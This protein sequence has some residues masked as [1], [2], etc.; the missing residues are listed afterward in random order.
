[1][2]TWRDQ[3]GTSAVGFM[4]SLN[5]PRALWILFFISHY[6]E[7]YHLT[8]AIFSFTG[9]FTMCLASRFDSSHVIHCRA[10]KSITNRTMFQ[11][12]IWSNSQNWVVRQSNR[13]TRQHR[14]RIHLLQNW[15]R[16]EKPSPSVHN[17]SSK[18]NNEGY[19]KNLWVGFD[20]SFRVSG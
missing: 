10:C 19:R 16:P 11:S 15:L 2:E 4:G 20:A 9:S 13:A 5:R 1:M 3:N 14:S 17:T 18:F 6:R 12:S 7:K 8:L